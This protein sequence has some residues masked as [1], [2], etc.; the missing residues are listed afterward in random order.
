MWATLGPAPYHSRKNWRDIVGLIDSG[1][2]VDVIVEAAAKASE[3]DLS[4]AGKDRRFQFL[5]SLLVRRRFLRARARI[6]RC[7]GRLRLRTLP[8]TLQ[9]AGYTTKLS[10][11]LHRAAHS[12][13][14]LVRYKPIVLVSQ[15]SKAMVSNLDVFSTLLDY[16]GQPNEQG[17][18]AVPSR[19]LKPLLSGNPTD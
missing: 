8:A 3:R 15:R 11:N 14:L 16:A 10:G 7:I 9:N 17:N 13:P 1:A 18:M 19:S 2:S 4:K 6:R 5:A 12:V